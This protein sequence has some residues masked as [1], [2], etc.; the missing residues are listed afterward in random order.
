MARHRATRPAGLRRRRSC[1]RSAARRRPMRARSESAAR[2][3]ATT[4]SARCRCVSPQSMSA[5][6]GLITESDIFRALLE[7]FDAPDRAVRRDVL[8]CGRRARTYCRWSPRSRARTAPCASRVSWRCR[9]TIRRCAWCQGSRASTDGGGARR[10]V[11]VEPPRDE[12]RATSCTKWCRPRHRRLDDYYLTTL[13]CGRRPPS[14]G[15]GGLVGGSGPR[16]CSENTM[17]SPVSR[18]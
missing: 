7:V 18:A 1:A 12:H 5:L 13:S 10:R 11:E 15:G 4:R 17:P 8:H 14:S 9:V 2:L 6:V 3:C 16:S